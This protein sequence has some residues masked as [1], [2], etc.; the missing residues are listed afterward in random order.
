[1]P[2]PMT[3]EET[4]RT[5]FDE[6]LQSE[7]PRFAPPGAAA[8]HR[9]VRRRRVGNAAA[10]GVAVVALLGGGYIAVTGI[11]RSGSSQS[12]PP[13]AGWPSTPPEELVAGGDPE[14]VRLAANAVRYD[15]PSNPAVAGLISEV[16]PELG[17][18]EYRPGIGG[19]FLVQI[20]C[21]GPGGSVTLTARAADGDPHSATAQ[22]ATTAG[23]VAAG[24]GE[25]TVEVVDDSD[26]IVYE[27]AT[28]KTPQ[29]G[30]SGIWPIV[31]ATF[32][33]R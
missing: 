14:L 15:D 4:I 7:P 32:T 28:N 23:E 12:V 5:A 33:R 30:S 9:S 3:E 29:W 6:L 2:N 1:M 10:A 18:S 17:R 22:C 31:A 21:A 24:V 25:A 16:T 26:R 13:G 27:F 19:T 11:D 20:S 8:A